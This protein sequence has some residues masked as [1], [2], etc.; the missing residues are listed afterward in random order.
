MKLFIIIEY[1]NNIYI[2]QLLCAEL[3]ACKNVFK[4][5]FVMVSH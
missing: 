2:I 5:P 4:N 1:F 3:Y